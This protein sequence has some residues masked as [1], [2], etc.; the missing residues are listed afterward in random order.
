MTADCL[1]D[2]QRDR[3]TSKEYIDIAAKSN[4]LFVP[5]LL[6]CNEDEHIKRATSFNRRI[7]TQTKLTDPELL[8]K[9]REEE[10]LLTFG[11]PSEMILD[12]T[13][14]SPKEAA[15]AIF[16]HVK[17]LGRDPNAPTIG[18]IK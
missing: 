2:N 16:R 13:K 5:I 10:T 14:E 8:K 9:I 18:G 15:R 4:R 3:D 12:I 7:P 11:I 6:Q 1:A 17:E